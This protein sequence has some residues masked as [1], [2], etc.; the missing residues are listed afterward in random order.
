MTHPRFALISVSNKH[1]I[2]P[3]AQALIQSG[4][5]ILSSG[6]SAEHLKAHG[7][8]VTEVSEYTGFAEMM[9]GRIKT[10]HPLIHGGILARRDTPDFEL[11]RSHGGQAIDIVI[12]NLYP[13]AATVAKGAGF[14]E[15]IENI[16]I[17]G[18][19]LI[20]GAAKNHHAVTVV[21]D[22]DDYTLVEQAL[23]AGNIGPELRAQLA[24]KAFAHTAAYDAHIANY[25][26]SIGAHALTPT[27]HLALE[28][29]SILR[30]GENPHQQAALYATHPAPVGT[31]TAARSLN[32]QAKALSYN[33]YVDCD[34]ALSCVAEFSEP[35]VVIV[36][37]NNPCGVATAKTLCDAFVA[38]RDADATSAFG[39][40]AAFNQAVDL[41]T[42]QTICETFFEC[43]VAPAYDNDALALL[44]SKKN[45]RIL[46]LDTWPPQNPDKLSLKPIR[47]GVLAQ[48][49]DTVNDAEV[50]NA[51]AV[52]SK[53]PDVATLAA[54]NFAWKVCKHV[55]SN[56]IVIAQRDG[57]VMRTVGVGAG[58]MS[59]VESV[60]IAVRKATDHIQNAVLASDAFFP[61]ADGLELAA[62]AGIRAVAQPG[63]SVRDEEVIAAANKHGVAMVFTATRHFN[64]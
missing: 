32:P 50:L 28:R 16:D 25:F 36:K 40:I 17:G 46:S 43:L 39:G 58:Q 45:L 9:G 62:Q 48:T 5:G 51:K 63:G 11:L 59:R 60:N 26:S 41:K 61:F 1:G 18:P 64:H 49:H 29:A 15:V 24:A 10:L 6:G 34:A 42:A 52:T 35:S 38:A 56:A 54:L 23:R 55:K 12:C 21:V 57:D 22:P 14:A 7:I 20:R 13:F 30:Y 19:T 31:L 44:N 47:G 33:N 3:L 2:E 27:L 4:Y 37:H 53:T 8:A